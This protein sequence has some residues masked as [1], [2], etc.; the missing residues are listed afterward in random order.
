MAD[1][2][3]YRVEPLTLRDVPEQRMA[4]VTLGLTFYLDQPLVWAREA[5]ARALML[6]LAHAP[7]RDHWWFITSHR[8]DWS[9]VNRD[10]V[11]ALFDGL[12]SRKL[13]RPRHLF[14]LQL[15]DETTAPGAGFHYREID[16]ARNDRTPVLQMRWP[17]DHN[18]VE[19]VRVA[20][21]VVQQ[22]P[23]WSGIGGYLATWNAHE[24]APSFWGIH[25]W[26]RRYLGL[27]V[28]DTEEMAWCAKQGLPGTNWLNIL[29]APLVEALGVDVDALTARE[30]RH[31]VQTS[32]VNQALFVAAGAKP[33]LGD[34]NWLT[35][36][37][38]YAEVARALEP[39]VVADPPALPGGFWDPPQ[40]LPWMRRFL[41]AR[42][43]RGD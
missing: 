18:P 34:V 39:Y 43:W 6:Y 31:G 14:E 25:G 29:G 32:R 26:C 1:D 19:L 42:G 40:T 5:A 30:W 41:E 21:A 33:T 35:Y 16:P 23:L 27:D 15:V 24:K 10:G 2:A 4:Q 28:Q 8:T 12:S 11:E 38:A 3:S 17:Q 13:L 7:E 37:E 36:P 20:Q 22:W 9:R